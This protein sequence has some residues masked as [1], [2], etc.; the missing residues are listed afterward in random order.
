M[1]A[2]KIVTTLTLG[3]MLLFG[4]SGCGQST[5]SDAT[6]TAEEPTEVVAEEPTAGS[7]EVLRVG[8]DLKFPPYSF[9]DDDGNPSGFEPDVSYA[10]GEYLGMDIEIVNTDFSLL[11]PALETGDV[12]VLIA[13]MARTD[14]RAEK[15]DFSAPYRYGHTLAL[16]NKDFAEANGITNDMPEEEFFALDAN[17]IGLSGTKGVYYP[18]NYGIMVT[19]VTEIGTGLIEV[20]NGMSDILVASDEVYG[21]QAADPENTIVYTGIV[22]QDA[23]NFAVAKGNTDLLDKANDFIDYMYEDGSVY[24]QLAEKW[25]PIVGEFLQND[26]LGL[27]Y[28]VSPN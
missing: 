10:F 24:D 28:I 16:V 4:L 26:E 12:D 20:S 21:F 22:P 17:F 19:E 14:E 9:M 25:D 23:S 2:N 6:T 5:S 8:M 13:D 7:G 15:V 18:Q 1:K 27:S 3:G 11:I